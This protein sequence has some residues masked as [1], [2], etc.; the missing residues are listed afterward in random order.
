M[1]GSPPCLRGLVGDIKFT[2]VTDR[3]NPAFAGQRLHIVP[4]QHAAS[5]STPC[6]RGRVGSTVQERV[7]ARFTPVGTGKSRADTT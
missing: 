1:S 4:S 3:F 7:D 2:S 6:V 5:G